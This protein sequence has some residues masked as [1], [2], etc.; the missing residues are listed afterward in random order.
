MPLNREQQDLATHWPNEE[1]ERAR[2]AL[3]ALLSAIITPANQNP[4]MVGAEGLRDPE[5]RSAM[6]ERI[7]PAFNPVARLAPL[8]SRA[9]TT[10]R[11][12]VPV[13]EP[14]LP[15]NKLDELVRS[16]AGPQTRRQFMTRAG[17]QLVSKPP[18][19]FE[20]SAKAAE[21]AK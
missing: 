12:L 8:L 11:S 5:K 20:M 17:A 18:I 13:A 7:M 21:L 10:G 14:G 2:N 1:G 15:A 19:S 16:V 6:I 3:E 9:P 4:L